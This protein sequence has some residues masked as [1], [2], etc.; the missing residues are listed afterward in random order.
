ME[1]GTTFVGLDVHVKTIAVAVAHGDGTVE[2]KGI[3][4]NTPR[5][6]TRLLRHYPAEHLSVCYEAGPCGFHLYRQLT[7][8]GIRCTVVAPSL[9]PKRAGK[10]VKTDRIDAEHLARMLRSGDL[11]AVAP[12]TPEL[13]AMRDLSRARQTAVEDLQRARQ[14]LLKLLHRKGISEPGSPKRWTQGWWRWLQT[15]TLSWPAEQT[16]LRYY[17]DA[18]VETQA[19]V[20]HLTLAVRSLA[21]SNSMTPVI[22]ALDAMHGVGEITALG[23]VAEIGDFRRFAHPRELMAYAGL[24]PSEHS[25]GSR[26]QR[27]RITKTGNAHVRRLV[28]EAAWHYT[29]PINPK[30]TYPHEIAQETRV[31][32]YRRYKHFVSG[33]KAPQVAIIAVAREL[34]GFLWSAAVSVPPTETTVTA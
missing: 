1:N 2:D 33:R 12:P 13:E 31:R 16:T 18:I 23:L 14:R 4:P 5:T 27:G 20:D 28:V 22:D 30:T 26:Q 11:V 32:L 6:I 15:V 17:R 8:M 25:S 7:G 9:I 34:L 10:R 3:H 21:S 19:R 24:V 29:R